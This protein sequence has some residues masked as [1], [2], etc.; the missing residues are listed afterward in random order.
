MGDLVIAEQQQG[1]RGV[2]DVQSR[3]VTRL[4]E[5]AASAQAAWHVAEHLVQTSF[6]PAAFR[7]RP[8]EA[9]AA[10]LA[11]IEVGLSPMA[12]LRAFDVIGGVAAPRAITLRAVAQSMGHD[13]EVTETSASRCVVRARRRGGDWQRVVWTIER[14]RDL[15]LAGKAPWRQQPQAMLVARATAE[16]ARLVAADAILGI[17]LA[18]EEIDGEAPPA[19]ASATAPEEAPAASGTRRMSRPRTKPAPPPPEPPPEP[20][21]DAPLP[22]SDDITRSQQAALHAALTR[23]GL[24]DRA[25]KLA[26]CGAQ[27]GHDIGSSSDLTKAEASVLLDLLARAEAELPEAV[28]P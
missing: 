8:E 20:D 5:W 25:E 15:G 19:E 2:V 10:I 18:I 13:I 26:W 28:E 16:A 6:V 11:G 17:G 14:A 27:I 12:S 4:A 3:A 24:T 9:T 7:G 23:A 22:A 21:D 1:S